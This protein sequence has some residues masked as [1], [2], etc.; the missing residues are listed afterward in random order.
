MLT[1]ALWPFANHQENSVEMDSHCMVVT[2]P[3]IAKGKVFFNGLAPITYMSVPKLQVAI[4][5]IVQLL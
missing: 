3:H 5:I 2:K 1:V 4:V